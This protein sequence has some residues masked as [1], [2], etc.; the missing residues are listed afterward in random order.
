MSGL[1][2]TVLGS[3]DAFATGGR[4]YSSYLLEPQE[5]RKGEARGVLLD[6][7]P[8]AVPMLMAMGFDMARLDLIL[9]SH[10]HGD[11]VLGMP[12]VFLD[13]QFRTK[14]K[15]PL[16][17]AGP[18]GTEAKC[19]ALFRLAYADTLLEMGRRFEVEYREL[20][21][22]GESEACGLRVLPRKVVHQIHEIP[23]GY[24]IAWRGRTLAWTGDTQWDE[25]VVDL[26][27]GADLLIAECFT[28]GFQ[29]KFHT[30]LEDLE[31]NRGRLEARRILLTHLG[32]T[33]LR[34]MAGGKLPFETA[35]EG[36]RIEV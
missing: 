17:V 7:G 35:M 24:R 21:E 32:E 30:S 3:G 13:A 8:T 4:P 6:C 9:L 12:M 14:R 10:L 28:A 34:R 20:P 19:E 33:M 1:A 5:E 15:N 29:L 16:V 22:G 27:R 25:A 23:Y 31:R 2:L 26:A 18:P 11:H 36:Q